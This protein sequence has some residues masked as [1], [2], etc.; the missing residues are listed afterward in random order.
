MK[1]AELFI[2]QYLVEEL[3]PVACIFDEIIVSGPGI[4]GKC[5]RGPGHAS[6]VDQKNVLIGTMRPVSSQCLMEPTSCA[7]YSVGIPVSGQLLM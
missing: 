1:A 4:L 2:A 6:L 7:V 5:R 3:D